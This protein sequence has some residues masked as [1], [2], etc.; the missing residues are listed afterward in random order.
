[1]MDDELA[2]DAPRAFDTGVRVHEASDMDWA[3]SVKNEKH[4]SFL[5]ITA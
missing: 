4:F 1:M 2:D 5:F 3:V